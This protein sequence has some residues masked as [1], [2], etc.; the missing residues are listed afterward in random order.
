[1]EPKDHLF[2]I[3]LTDN[4]WDG[5]PYLWEICIASAQVFN[6]KKVTIYTNHKLHLSFLDRK[7]TEVIQLD[8]DILDKAYN[9]NPSSK[10]H[11]SDY[12][13]LWLLSQYG[14]TYFDT[15]ILFYGSYEDMW[16]KMKEANKNIAYP[17]EDKYMFT[18]CFIMCNNPEK[19]KPFFDNMFKEYET[20]FIRHSYLHNSQKFIDLMY[21][22]Y[23]NILAYEEP[24]L[25]QVTWN[26]KGYVQEFQEGRC[27]GFGQHLF[28]S[29]EE[30]NSERFR[31]SQHCYDIDPKDFPTKLSRIIIDSY[32]DLMKE[33]DNN[34]DK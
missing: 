12:L 18:N 24:S 3:W 15:D 7:I 6:K 33:A 25:F 32:I 21:R 26:Y 31:I 9:I 30:W 14:G 28:S 13:R 22:R 8:K 11:Q 19:A 23:N 34:V 5:M 29:N 27:A 2:T 16:N 4:D 20:R 17:K 10:A 1:M